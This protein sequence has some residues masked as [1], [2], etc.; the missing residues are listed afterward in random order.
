MPKEKKMQ[1][2]L[3]ESKYGEL[4]NNLLDLAKLHNIYVVM[5]MPEK[6]KKADDIIHN[7]ALVLTPDSKSYTYRKIHL[8]LDEP[9]WATSGDEPVLI[10]TPWG[11]IG[12]ALCYDMY[13]FPELIRYYVA[14][15]A[16]LIINSTAYARSRGAAKGKTT[17]EST[18]LM[19]GVYV[20]TA[21]L[22]G[23]DLVNDFWG[24]SSII[25]PSRKMQEVY[26]YA[27]RPFDAEHA[28]EEEVY[29]ATIDLS[30]AERGIYEENSRL[31][32]PDFRPNLYAKWYQELIEINE[33]L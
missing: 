29:I 7:T 16:R 31:G 6:N 22:C 24:G 26:Y 9:N 19:N 1:V 10:D 8:A 32:H 2:R 25:G 14:K 12:I 28:G 15:G 18:V 33:E 20:A 30:L 23:K 21:N 13:A 5:G 11:P 4:V 17:L 27:G 3:A